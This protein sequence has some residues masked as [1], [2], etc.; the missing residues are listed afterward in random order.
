MGTELE[1]YFL[2]GMLIGIAYPLVYECVQL[3]KQGLRSYAGDVW[4]YTDV[5]YLF[6]SVINV[7]VTLAIGPLHALSRGL[8]SIITLLIISKTMFFLRI[9]GSFSPVVIMV[10]SV[11][12]ELRVYMVIYFFIA[13]VLSLMFNVLGVG[14]LKNDDPESSIG[15]VVQTPEYAILGNLVGQVIQSVRLSQVDPTSIGPYKIS[16]SLLGHEENILFWLLWVF[17]AI[18]TNV[19]YLNFIVAEVMN[20]YGKVTLTLGQVKTR[21]RASMIAESEYMTWMHGKAVATHP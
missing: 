7:L 2:V 9:V 5:V 8:M 17:G 3:K 6:M 14:L 1:V 13:F 21:E 20:I 19:I 18:L 12:R 10:T 16:I 4:N 11:L 15:N